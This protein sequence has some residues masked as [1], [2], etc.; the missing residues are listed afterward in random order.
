MKNLALYFTLL[1]TAS[2]SEVWPNAKAVIAGESPKTAE[3]IILT[4]AA[5]KIAASFNITTKGNGVI[6]IPGLS[7]RVYDSHDDGLIFRGGLLRCEWNFEHGVEFVVS[8][9]AEK[10]EEKK[11]EISVRGV[12][13]YSSSTKIFEPIVCSP[14]ID[15]WK[16]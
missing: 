13:R 8:G 14:Q 9:I 10:T 16:E 12:F 3:K 4:P 1:A 5:L 6:S 7:I 2:A 11:E 15:Y